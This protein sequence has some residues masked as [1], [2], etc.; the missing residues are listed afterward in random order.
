LSSI[1]VVRT[2]AESPY[3]VPLTLL[4]RH[5]LPVFAA[6][7]VL[8]MLLQ[9]IKAA[10]GQDPFSDGVLLLSGIV[11][12]LA[13]ADVLDRLK[14]G[15]APVPASLRVPVAPGDLVASRAS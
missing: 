7:S 6:G 13:L 4:G 10:I 12:L 9:A 8:D 14:P 11:L 1:P 15:K 3:A 5:G 2:I